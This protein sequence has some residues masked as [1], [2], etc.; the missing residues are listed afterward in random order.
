[1]EVQAY[2]QWKYKSKDITLGR[3]GYNLGAER[4]PTLRRHTIETHPAS[5]GNRV[6]LVVN[7][8]RHADYHWLQSDYGP[9]LSNMTVGLKLTL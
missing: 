3:K 9:K 5:L 2:I 6:S 1:M 7:M 4:L 8:T